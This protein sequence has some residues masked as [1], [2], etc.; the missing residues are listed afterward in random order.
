MKHTQH[1]FARE[2]KS[3][4]LG[5]YKIFAFLRLNLETVVTEDCEAVKNMVGD[6]LM[7]MTKPCSC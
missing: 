2:S 4:H 7:T 6:Y 5:Q 3:I 1:A